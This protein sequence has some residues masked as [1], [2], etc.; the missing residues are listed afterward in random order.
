MIKTFIV[1][2]YICVFSTKLMLISI[3][4]PD[5]SIA[6]KE[7]TPKRQKP[8][9]L[10]SCCRR[11]CHTRFDKCFVR[12]IRKEYSGKCPRSKA[13]Y[14]F[15]R[16]HDA[17]WRRATPLIYIRGHR[18]CPNAFSHCLGIGI[19][20]YYRQLGAFHGGART[21]V[22][23]ARKK[24]IKSIHAINWFEKYFSQHGDRMP[25]SPDILLP[26]KTRIIHLFRDYKKDCVEGLLPKVKLSTFYNLRKRHFSHVRVKKVRL[27][28][29]M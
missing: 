11:K 2:C 24:A 20:T 13:E 19:S 16:L 18:M 28:S 12:Q 22:D 26:Y 15:D 27:L 9:T 3:S 4:A 23:K 5:K 21:T 8:L 10:K 29:F 1:R 14:I 25:D 7:T 6:R 17:D